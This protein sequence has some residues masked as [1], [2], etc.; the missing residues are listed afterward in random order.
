MKPDVLEYL[1]EKSNYDQEKTKS[2]VQGFRNGFD[3]GYRNEKNVTRTAP[4]LKLRIGNL[5]DIWNKVMAEVKEKRY[6]GPFKKLPFEEDF[7]Q[8]PIGLVPKDGGRKTRLIF[9]LSYPKNTNKS[10]NANTPKELTS[11]QYPSFDEAVQLCLGSGKGCAA[12]KSDLTAAFRHLPIAKKFWKYL[13]MKAKSPLDGKWYYFVDKCLP[14][15]ASISCAL[16]QAFSNALAHI[17]RHFTKKRNIN[18]LDDYLF[19]H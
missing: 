10:V 7:I 9:H 6:A 15:G 4:N 11:V 19:L 16:F 3:L 13:V 2:L 12:G 5:T 17:V 14:F 1:L 18:Y 8:S